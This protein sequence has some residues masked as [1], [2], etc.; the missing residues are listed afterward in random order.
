MSE[1]PGAADIP[2]FSDLEDEDLAC[3]GLRRADK[4]DFFSD[5]D[6]QWKEQ[7]WERYAA[8]PKPFKPRKPPKLNIRTLIE[9]AKAAGATAVT[10]PDGTRLDFA[11]SDSKQVNELDQWIAKHADK[12]QRY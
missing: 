6:K 7:A 2:D 1:P 12:T 5:L 3:L 10:L 4:D 8:L 9:Q 11:G